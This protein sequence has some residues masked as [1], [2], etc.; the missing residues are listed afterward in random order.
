MNNV[1]EP[2]SKSSISRVKTPIKEYK[3][4]KK[5]IKISDKQGIK[6]LNKKGK[7]PNNIFRF[8]NNQVERGNKHPAPFNKE[9]PSWFIKALTDKNDIILDPFM[10]SGTTAIS[11]IELERK[12]IGFELN[13]EYIK[14]AELKIKN[15]TGIERFFN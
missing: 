3:T 6:K 13:N 9:L 7:I 15:L 2:Y 11:A 14:L 4:N 1:R 8:Q 12:W 5:G 10:G